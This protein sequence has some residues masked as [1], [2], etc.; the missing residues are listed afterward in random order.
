MKRLVMMLAV[1]TAWVAMAGAEE[2]FFEEMVAKPIPNVGKSGS[3]EAQLWTFAHS[4]NYIREGN[5]SESGLDVQRI[6]GMKETVAIE[7]VFKDP[8]LDA[9]GRAG[10]VFDCL[11]RRPDGTLASDCRNLR[12]W[13]NL[14]PMPAG[15]YIS[16]GSPLAFS[17]DQGD[18]AGVYI[19][20]VVV[21]DIPGKR[22]I[23]LKTE[24]TFKR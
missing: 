5:L 7:L 17:P 9:K 23:K 2:I 12:G 13:V 18:P 4:Y 11:I 3:F 8:A 10:V 6:F 16:A 20:E 22:T 15:E 1:F 19:V 14:S 21:R 24:F